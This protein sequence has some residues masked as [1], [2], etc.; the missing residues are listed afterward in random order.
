[1]QTPRTRSKQ[2]GVRKSSARAPGAKKKKIRR[3]SIIDKT[4]IPSGYQ[5]IRI[6][7][8]GHGKKF[9]LSARNLRLHDKNYKKHMSNHNM[10]EQLLHILYLTKYLPANLSVSTIKS[11]LDVSIV[12]I[13]TAL[14]AFVEEYN[15]AIKIFPDQFKYTTLSAN[16]P[17]FEANIKGDEFESQYADFLK[18]FEEKHGPLVDSFVYPPDFNHEETVNDEN[19]NNLNNLNSSSNVNNL[20]NLS[21]LSNL[22][23]SDINQDTDY[24]ELVIEDDD[25]DANSYVK[26]IFFIYIHLRF[27]CFHLRF[28]CL[29]SFTVSMFSFSMYV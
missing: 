4:E 11:K 8:R 6:Q 2:R 19:S 13:E 29:H 25:N 21:N 17:N 22:N 14:T 16:V 5:Y 15:E 3:K 1:M 27:L 20:S 24:D 10:K 23:R 18:Q 26:F 7:Q 28:L 12:D 9:Y